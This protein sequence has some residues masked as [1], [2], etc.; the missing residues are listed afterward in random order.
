MAERQQSFDTLRQYIPDGSFELVMPLII[1]HRVHLIITRER[2]TKLGDYRHAHSGKNHRIS[3]NGN[4]N[5]YAFLITLLHELAH[6]L[7]YQQHGPRIAPHGRE[8]KN[9][10]RALFA[11]FLQFPV[12]PD[13]IAAE[14]KRLLKSPAATT[15]GETALQRIL[16]R[17]DPHKPGYATVEELEQGA[18][19]CISNGRIFVRG[20]QVRKRIR[21]TEIPGNKVY[22]FHPLYEVKTA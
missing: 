21:C 7:A 3:V 6:L 13:D 5:R 11:E 12:F 22:L 10:Y 19:F 8:W 2:Q 16:R 9:A 15:S 14:L 18:R 4:L 20:A 17:Y 1:R